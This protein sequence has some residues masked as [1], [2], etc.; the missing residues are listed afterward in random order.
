M[1]ATLVPRPPPAPTRKST[2]PLRSSTLTLPR[3]RA[4]RGRSTRRRNEDAV[5]PARRLRLVHPERDRKRLA[6]GHRSGRLPRC[7]RD[8]RLDGIDRRQR[9]LEPVRV[10]HGLQLERRCDRA[11]LDDDHR[12]ERR[13][14]V[15]ERLIDRLGRFDCPTGQSAALVG[16][17]SYSTLSVPLSLNN[18][19][20]SQSGVD[21]SSGVVERASAT[22]AGGSCGTFG[23]WSTVTLSGGADTTVAT[24]TCYRYRYS[25]SDNVGN[26]RRRRR[27]APPPRSTPALRRSTS[28][29]RRRPRAPPSS[30]TAQARPRSG[31]APPAPGRSP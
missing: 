16:G 19:S 5:V 7:L 9:Q 8:E 4:E 24:D 28:I 23:T 10:A 6:V 29:P 30:T 1:S 27:R 18:G 26:A 11:R 21:S 12:H 25:V 22:L 14:S 13:R 15:G 31:S 17:P 2:P 3:S 20:D